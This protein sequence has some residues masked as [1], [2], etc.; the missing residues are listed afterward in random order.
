MIVGLIGYVVSVLATA[1]LNERASILSQ[2]TIGIIV[3]GVLFPISVAWTFQA[4]FLNQL[5][6]RDEALLVPI[7]L[8]SG[9]IAFLASA[10]IG[11]RINRFFDVNE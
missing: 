2:I 1:A 10:I 9:I 3:S 5:T 11:P 8:A 6:F 4:G 7:H